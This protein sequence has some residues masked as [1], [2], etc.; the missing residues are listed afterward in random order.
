MAKI[1]ENETNLAYRISKITTT[2]FSF[3]DKLMSEVQSIFASD[4]ALKTNLNISIDL[5]KERSEISFEIHSILWNT[6][7][8]EELVKHT[9]K[10]IFSL[11][12]LESSYNEEA[13]TYSLP[14]A[15]M[16]QFYS[17]AYTHSRALLSVE[18]LKTPYREL[19]FLPVIDPK[20]IL[21]KKP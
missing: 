14:D 5:N 7:T 17:I 13:D 19:Y 21:S 9:G 6:K 18:L 2:E 20:S 16:V 4:D 3:V 8:N 12:D 10:T 1:K 15:L 11:V